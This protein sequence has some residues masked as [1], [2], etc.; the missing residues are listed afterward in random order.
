[1][2]DRPWETEDSTLAGNVSSYLVNFASKGDPNSAKLTYWPKIDQNQPQIMELGVHLGPM[3]LAGRE[4]LD[5]WT[6]YYN[7]PISRSMSF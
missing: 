2:L 5:F 1:M 3:P 7:S 6:R 4:K